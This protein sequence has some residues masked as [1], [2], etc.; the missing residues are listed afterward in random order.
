[1]EHILAKSARLV[2]QTPTAFSRY[3]L[4]EIRWDNRLIGIK[5]ARG[6]GKTTLILQ[7]LKRLALPITKAAYFSLDD[8]FFTQYS[9]SGTIERFC[10]EGGE[11]VFLDEVHKYPG[12]AKEIKNLHDFYPDLKIVFT[13]SSIIDLAREEGDLSRRSLI[14]E[15]HGLSYR[16]YLSLEGVLQIPQLMLTDLLEKGNDIRGIFP[17]NFKP[18]QHF[19]KYLSH[20]Y[21]PFYKDDPEGFH[22]RLSQMIRFAIEYDMASIKGFDPRNARKL[23]QLLFILSTNVP[24]KPNLS[25]LAQKAD[26]HRNSVL[27][28]LIHLDNARLIR[29]LQPP[30]YGLALL[31]KPE[32]IFLNNTNLAYALTPAEPNTGNLRETFFYSQ[33]QVRHHVSGPEQGDFFVDNK[34]T[35][36]IGGRQKGYEQIAGIPHSI[37]VRDEMEYP[38][39]KFLPLWLFGFLY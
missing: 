34:Y 32:K 23:L 36:E 2:R 37:V 27:N 21:Y 3:L 8:I 19:K 31:Q 13:G 33:L 15:L 26:I 4:H 9:L 6:V 18:L 10:L 35:F 38:S 30:G 22:Q 7:Q 28:Y 39:G 20:G 1:M 24:F 25:Q 29:L 14:Y 16:E 17:E 5:G 11:V 12:W